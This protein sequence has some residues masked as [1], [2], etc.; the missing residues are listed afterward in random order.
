M[1]RDEVDAILIDRAADV[2]EVSTKGTV[3]VD[4]QSF[5]LNK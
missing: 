3:R 2:R 5:A 4:V 1:E